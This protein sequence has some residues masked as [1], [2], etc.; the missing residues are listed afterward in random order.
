[1]K[2]SFVIPCY[3]SEKT[4]EHVVDEI[5]VVMSER[6]KNAYEIIL[7][8]DCSPDNVYSIISE[9]AKENSQIKVINFA[10]NFGKASAVLAGF[11]VAS[12][13]IIVNLDDDGQ[14]PLN[15]TGELIDALG[16]KYDISMAAYTVK[17]ESLYKRIGSRANAYLM[18]LLL[19][20]PPNV[21]TSNFWAVKKF[22]AKEMIRYM[23]T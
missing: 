13:D 9:L 21:K 2:I 18:S 6:P 1:M 15:Y 20:Q 11:R 17:L 8:N 12:G 22:V 19:D 5:N 23:D 10:R 16:E 7:V 3:R 4:I 14:C